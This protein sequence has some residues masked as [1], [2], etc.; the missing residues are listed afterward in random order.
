MNEE[1]L[2]NTTLI[3][4]RTNFKKDDFLQDLS[5]IDLKDFSDSVLS[6]FVII[7]RNTIDSQ[8]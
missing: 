2:K 3:R 1:Q 5:N 6:Q 8:N 7:N 4:D